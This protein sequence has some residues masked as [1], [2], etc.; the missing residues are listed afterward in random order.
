MRSILPA[1]A[2]MNILMM[3]IIQKQSQKKGYKSRFEN[4]LLDPSISQLTNNWQNIPSS[5]QWDHD[6]IFYFPVSKQVPPN[7]WKCS[8]RL[9]IRLSSIFKDSNNLLF[10]S[11]LPSTEEISVLSPDKVDL[12]IDCK[13][14]ILYKNSTPKLSCRFFVHRRKHPSAILIYF[15]VCLYLFILSLH[16]V[17]VSTP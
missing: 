11:W 8:S 14:C 1:A 7:I 4:Q 17:R 13:F 16:Q 10:C 3:L 6:T 15:L 2:A 12:L 9:I 5:V